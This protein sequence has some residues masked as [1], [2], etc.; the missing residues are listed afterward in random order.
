MQVGDVGAEESC[1][2]HPANRVLT[3]LLVVTVLGAMLPVVAAGDASAARSKTIKIAD[4]SIV[5]GDS[6][7]KSL[8][9]KVT[10]SGSKG[11]GGSVS[12]GYATTAVTATAGSDYTPQ[13]G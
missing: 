4:A 3:R 7:S 11:G 6:G 8:S 9:F 5:E 12:V 13:A 2:R 1:V 10:W